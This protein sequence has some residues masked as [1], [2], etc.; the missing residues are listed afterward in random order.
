MELAFKAAGEGDLS[1]V[2]AFVLK[3]ADNV[4]TKAE[5]TGETLLMEAAFKNQFQ[6]VKWLTLH[7]ANVNQQDEQ[8]HNTALI[9]AANEG[10]ASVCRWLLLNGA[11]PNYSNLIGCTALMEACSGKQVH[12]KCLTTLV[13][14]SLKSP[15]LGNVNVEGRSLENL[16]KDEERQGLIDRA[17]LKGLVK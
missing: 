4:N 13:A 11:D 7:H 5:D 6:V 1:T 3:A 15:V 14:Y 12:E 16:G 9:W 2:Q 10:N 17:I 8:F